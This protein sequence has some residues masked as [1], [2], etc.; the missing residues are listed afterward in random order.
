V[1]IKVIRNDNFCQSPRLRITVYL[2]QF[3]LGRLKKAKSMFGN[4]ID[5]GAAHDRVDRFFHLAMAA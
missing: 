4:Q 3:F 2:R 1:S 5:L